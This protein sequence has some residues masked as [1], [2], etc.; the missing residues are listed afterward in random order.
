MRTNKN[1]VNKDQKDK[2]KKD[3]YNRGQHCVYCLTYHMIFVKQYLNPEINDEKSAPMIEFKNKKEF[4]NHM[5]EQFR[6][7]VLSA[8]TDRDHI[9]LLVSL[10]PNTNISVFV[11]SIK[12][13]LSREM[14]KRFPEQIKQ[15]IYGDDTSFWSR[16][17]F[18]ATTGSVS[19]ETVKQ[20]I[21]SQRSEEHQAK[22]NQQFQKKTLLE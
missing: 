9:H 22:K 1:G 3:G 7:K 14:R 17:Y 8:E 21:E 12:T 10:P 2:V 15:Y 6:G 18:I 11:R 5:A 4:S 13:Q 20:Y 16:S 19:L